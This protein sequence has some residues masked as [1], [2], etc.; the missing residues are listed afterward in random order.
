MSTKRASIR[1]RRKEYEKAQQLKKHDDSASVYTAA[2]YDGQ[3]EAKAY[4]MYAMVHVMYERFGWNQEQCDTFVNRVSDDT[5]RS[6]QEGA[7]RVIAFVWHDR[8]EKAMPEIKSTVDYR[9]PTPE[10]IKKE[11][12]IKERNAYFKLICI[13]VLDTL[14][15]SKTYN[16]GNIRLNRVLDGMV[17]EYKLMQEKSLEWFIERCK[18]EVNIIWEM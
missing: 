4:V 16:F 10:Q 7:S 3:I 8:V 6:L 9:H 18:K 17:E 13:F 12:H 11:A 5:L 2:A 14:C 15:D 1:R